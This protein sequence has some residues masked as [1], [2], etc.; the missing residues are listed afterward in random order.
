MVF[1]VTNSELIVLSSNV[2]SL[3]AAKLSRIEK[4]AQEQR[5]HIICLQETWL[6][7]T[8]KICSQFS[9]RWQVL[10][11]DRTTGEEGGG[12]L[13]AC[14]RDLRIC[15]SRDHA[16]LELASLDIALKDNSFIRV[17]SLYLSPSGGIKTAFLL[18]VIVRVRSFIVE[19]L[20]QHPEAVSL[21]TAT[22]R[23]GVWYS[24]LYR[25]MSLE[26]R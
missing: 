6:K 16:H 17:G 2:K 3:S 25:L 22:K 5:A 7:P 26:I 15:A 14:R 18:K 24:L 20:I 11:R 12:V 1:D 13:I 23:D 10:R 21:R 19:T 9:Q 4:L 8:S